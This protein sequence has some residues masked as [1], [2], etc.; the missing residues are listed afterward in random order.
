MLGPAE[1][2]ALGAELAGF[3][4]IGRRVGVRPDPQAPEV[5]GPTQDRSEVLVDRGR[6]ERD[7]ADDHLTRSTVDRDDIAG[8]ELVLAQRD[9]A[10]LHVDGE[11][12]AACDAR[13]SLAS[14][15]D[16]G[17]RRHPAVGGQDPLG[18]VH[19]SVVVRGRLPADE[20]DVLARPPALLGGTRVEDD[21]AHRRAG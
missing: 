2:D 15:N 8:R 4:G 20:D 16:R 10:V 12:L 11:P 7:R 5:V 14:R 21:G 9:G 17:V 13:L 19:A 6:D 3:R 18:D 1:P